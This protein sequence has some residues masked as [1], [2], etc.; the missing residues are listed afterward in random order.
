MFYDLSVDV[1]GDKNLT[2]ALRYLVK[3]VLRSSYVPCETVNPLG[4]LREAIILSDADTNVQ[5]LKNVG[6]TY[7]EFHFWNFS[8]IISL[9]LRIDKCSAVVMKC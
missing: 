1:F 2:L 8:K 6:E 9:F 7:I 4:R 5:F 3:G